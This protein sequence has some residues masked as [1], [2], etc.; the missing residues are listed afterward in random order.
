MYNIFDVVV[1]GPP[2]HPPVCDFYLDPDFIYVGQTTM[3]T[4][5]PGISD[6]DGDDIVLY[7]YDYYYN[8]GIFHTMASNTTG[9]PI[10]SPPAPYLGPGP[11]DITM[12]LRITDDGVPPMSSMCTAVLTI[13]PNQGPVCDLKVDPE[14]IASGG[15]TMLS[16]GPLCSDPDGDIILYEYDFDY[17]LVTFN[18]DGSNTTGAPIE[19]T[20]YPNPGPDPI[21]K[22]VA[23]RVT[24]DGSPGLTSICTRELSIVVN[25]SPLCEL[26]L[27]EYEINSGA[28]VDCIPGPG[29]IDP[30]GAIILYEYDFDYDL[31]TFDVDGLNTT[32]D[33]VATGPID[34][35]TGNPAIYKIA[36]RV[37]DNGIPAATKICTQE[38]I[39]NPIMTAP[40]PWRN[41]AVRVTPSNIEWV[42]IDRNRMEN[43][44]CVHGDNVY[45]IYHG[46]VGGVEDFWIQ[47][48][49]DG[50][51]TFCYPQR[52]NCKMNCTSSP[53][54]E[55][56]SMDILAN[57][58]VGVATFAYNDNCLP[59]G[60][61][62][63]VRFWPVT[64]DGDTGVNIGS[65]KA[66]D[67]A[68]GRFAVSNN[69]GIYTVDVA[70]HPTDPDVC[71]V[72]AIDLDGGFVGD[73]PDDTSLWKIT[74]ITDSPVATIEF[75][76]VEPVCGAPPESGHDKAHMDAVCDYNGNL[77]VVW[78]SRDLGT[79]Y[80]SMVYGNSTF[81]FDH[82]DY[83]QVNQFGETYPE[84]AHVDI[85]NNNVAYIAYAATGIPGEIEPQE[86]GM[87]TGIGYPPEFP[88]PP[89]I[90]N[91]D[92]E[93]NQVYPDI[94]FDQTTGDLW[95]AYTT[96]AFGP[97]QITFELYDADDGWTQFE[98]D[99]WI[100]K[101]DPFNEH[102]DEHVHLFLVSSTGTAYAIWEESD[103][104]NSPHI[105]FNRTH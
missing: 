47:R 87:L 14:E 31:V 78:C 52:F 64:P 77:H 105:Y 54:N 70:A 55:F 80:Y 32:G 35:T 93:G 102:N 92:R 18:V 97:G 91:H 60:T 74:N 3:L 103:G 79:I 42:S 25:Q 22:T 27:S 17:D 61:E 46:V 49:S 15:T 21:T 66:L 53:H 67:R 104:P 1:T 98:P 40:N 37:T 23:L 7:E 63:K 6:P 85:D 4:P 72:D 10:E 62:A 13:S 100:N 19:T 20:P 44:L 28:S 34:N 16:P 88:D 101:D 33:P 45:V 24:D 50:G 8:D 59:S 71:F 38:L 86:I 26:I 29:T 2:Q 82:T 81:P 58:W 41:P 89:F 57:G 48:S 39:V 96:F 95:V 30:D 65:Y 76:V 56:V 99:Y 83:V 12:A 94:Q 84:G 73:G 36:M 90:L 9:D 68:T 11:V 75:A 43:N 69:E 5:G 51:V